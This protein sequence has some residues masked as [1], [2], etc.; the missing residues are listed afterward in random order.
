[1]KQQLGDKKLAKVRRETGLDIESA[2]VR[3]GTDHTLTL[4]LRDGR[5]LYL[6]KD[7][8]LEPAARMHDFEP[9]K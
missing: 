1:M 6:R 7:G 2:T 3:G 5:V 8:T 9:I 4:Y